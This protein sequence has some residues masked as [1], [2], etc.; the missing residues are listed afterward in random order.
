MTKPFHAMSKQLDLRSSCAS[1]QSDQH[2][3]CLLPRLGI[4]V[5][6]HGRAARPRALN[7]R[8]GA[9]KCPFGGPPNA[10]SSVHV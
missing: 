10:L 7:V 5:M 1:G 8:P 3:Q 6:R 9:L 2:I 4:P